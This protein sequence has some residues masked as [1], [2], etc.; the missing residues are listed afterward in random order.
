[1][2]L[3]L[4]PANIF[5]TFEGVLKIGD[6]GLASRWPAGNDVDGEGDREYISPEILSQGRV[7]KPAD[8][9]ALGLMALEIAGNFFLPDNGDQWQRLRSGNLSDI[10]SLTWSMDSRLSRDE[11]GDPVGMLWEDEDEDQHFGDEAPDGIIGKHGLRHDRSRGAH[12]HMA[13]PQDHRRHGGLFHPSSSPSPRNDNS[14]LFLT[15]HKPSSPA[16]RTTPPAPTVNTAASRNE[17]S[18]PPPFMRNPTDPHSL[19]HLVEWMLSPDPDVRPT[20]TQVL[21]SYGLGWVAARRRA[22]AT[23]YEGN[24]GPKVAGEEEFGLEEDHGQELDEEKQHGEDVEMED[25]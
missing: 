7:D 2:H 13:P 4:K 20:I 1:M 14:N 19:D 6:F 9:F 23:V 11:N 25:V 22:G 17:L 12:W 15:P 5:I 24:W 8:V 21:G 10:P 3:D 18:A 16:I